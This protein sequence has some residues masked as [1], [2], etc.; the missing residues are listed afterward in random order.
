MYTF[1]SYTITMLFYYHFMEPL[2]CFPLLL[3]A[4]EHF[5]ARGRYRCTA[6]IGA[7][8]LVA[9]INFYFSIGS[10]LAAA[11]YGLCRIARGNVA[12]KGRTI[13]SALGCAMVGILM[14][15]FILAPV[16]C[17]LN[18]GTREAVD[19]TYGL[20]ESLYLLGYRAIYMFMPKLSEGLNP[21]LHVVSNWSGPAVALPVVGCFFALLYLLRHKDWLSLLLGVGLLC[22]LTPLNG[23]FTLFTSQ[24]YVRWGYALCLFFILPTLRLID[25]G[26]FS[27]ADFRKYA[28]LAIGVVALYYAA[29][30][31]WF[32][33]RHLS[34]GD[35]LH[36]ADWPANLFL[37]FLLALSL[38]C[39]YAFVRTRRR[40]VLLWGIAICVGLQFAGSTGSREIAR[41][42]DDAWLANIDESHK[43]TFID[44][45][46][47]EGLRPFV[48]RTDFTISKTWNICLLT[49][50]PSTGSW[51]SCINKAVTPLIFSA[52]TVR[53]SVRM[54]Y[55][56]TCNRTSFDALMSVKQIIEYDKDPLFKA[57]DSLG[58]Y[59]FVP[60]PVQGKRLAKK[61]DNETIYNFDY[62]I[63]MGFTYDSYM[64][65]DVIM[66]F[67]TAKAVRMD[68]PLQLLAHLWVESGD[69]ALAARYMRRGAMT[70]GLS[71]DSVCRERRRQVCDRFEGDTRGF[72]AHVDM[73]K[74]NLLF[75]SVP[76]D[77]GFK[78]TVDGKPTRILKAN[79]GLSAIAVDK[80]SHDIRFEYTPEGLRTG[81][82]VSLLALLVTLA[83]V[84]WERKQRL[85][86]HAS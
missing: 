36:E 47:P 68:I 64:D 45:S 12:G 46:H 40:G 4:I 35:F 50:R 56:P 73:R 74:A 24:T 54:Q 43:V 11:I 86:G 83:V 70:T 72:S 59:K 61:T 29:N 52:D 31:V 79:L 1:S 18:G 32:L 7:S 85:S 33:K 42:K 20:S 81:A 51:S 6:L 63:P 84:V 14:A 21:Y 55:H 15:S 44:T 75:F 71:L 5:L 82:I 10:F 3:M 13:A 17:Y 65:Q 48:Y 27:K 41:S 37:L 66:P 60:A 78:A 34:L 80:G 62:Y 39:L 25:Q 30:S 22:Y 67:D 19:R 38:V 2:I 23:A 76:A 8:F 28:L 9:F 57:K 53:Q 69:T 77:P 49:D 26:E 58:R 16:F